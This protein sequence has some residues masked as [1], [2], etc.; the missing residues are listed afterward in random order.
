[1]A[2]SLPNDRLDAVIE[3]PTLISKIPKQSKLYRPLS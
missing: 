1:M 3:D 2:V